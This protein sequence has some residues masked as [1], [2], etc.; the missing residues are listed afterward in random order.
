[1][2]ALWSAARGEE[3][4]ALTHG[5]ADSSPT[6]SPD[7][8]RLAFLRAQDGP[9]QVWLLPAAGGEAEQLTTLPLG[10]GAPVWSPDG[11]AIAFAAP[12]DRDAAPDEDESARERRSRSP[13]VT[14]RL[15]YQADGAG[16]LRGLRKHL[17]V[18]DVTNGSQPEPVS[19]THLTLPT[20][21]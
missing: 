8:S 14:D 18:V 12:V 9:P 21:A 1:M 16:F 20:K 11:A 7:G 15:G 10:A 2:R 5:P 6:W 4:R 19:Y 17:H 3:P 13:I